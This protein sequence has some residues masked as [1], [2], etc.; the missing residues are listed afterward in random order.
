MFTVDGEII[1][2]EKIKKELDSLGEVKN[3]DLFKEV[4]E[5]DN[6]VVKSD[7]DQ[8]AREYVLSQLRENGL[9]LK[10]FDQSIKDDYECVITA[11][12][13]NYKAYEFIGEQYKF[14]EQ[15]IDIYW[16]Q[17]IAEQEYQRKR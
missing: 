13:S 1:T 16:T 15:V 14:D 9:V 12:T 6:R 11:M 4:T 7:F 3:S 17:Y 5:T 8:K 10:Y 2:P